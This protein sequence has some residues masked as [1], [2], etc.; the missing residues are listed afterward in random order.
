MKPALM[1]YLN[2]I[3]C[4]SILSLEIFDQRL[5]IFLDEEKG[6]I[7]QT[8]R[9]IFEYETEIMRGILICT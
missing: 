2:C 5:A 6:L 4:G 1:K 8:K 7:L 3:N 9:D